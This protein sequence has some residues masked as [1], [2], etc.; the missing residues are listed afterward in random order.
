[1]S[2][3]LA[4]RQGIRLNRRE[5][6]LDRRACAFRAASYVARSRRA[7]GRSRAQKLASEGVML[8][9]AVGAAYVCGYRWSFELSG[10]SLAGP[11]ATSIPAAGKHF[12][13]TTRRHRYSTFGIGQKD[14]FGLAAG[15]RETRC[16]RG[17]NR[18]VSR[19]TRPRTAAGRRP[20]TISCGRLMRHPARRAGLGMVPHIWG[21][22]TQELG[23]FAT[24]RYAEGKRMRQAAPAASHPAH[25][26]RLA[27]ASC[28]G[29]LQRACRSA[30]RGGEGWR[31][32]ARERLKAAGMPGTPAM[33]GYWGCRGTETPDLRKCR[34][35]A[36]AA[37]Q[38]RPERSRAAVSLPAAPASRSS[39]APAVPRRASSPRRRASARSAR[40]GS[41][42]SP[43]RA[44]PCRRAC[45][46]RA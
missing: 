8:A 31:R 24:P 13:S 2:S 27:P 19:P 37:G 33:S 29:L 15:C 12:P 28:S 18:V 4:A 23:H 35:G 42:R 21:I 16:C 34:R 14:D 44:V 46:T 10:A 32:A 22:V 40:R 36:A 39:P 38:R 17:R 11:I 41:C 9:S 6:P 5:P 20:R 7:R 1:M 26:M 25:W 45:R 30:P 43:P 3:S